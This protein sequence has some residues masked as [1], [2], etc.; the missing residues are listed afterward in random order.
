MNTH[1]KNVKMTPRGKDPVTLDHLSIRG[2]TIR[3]VILPDRRA[4]CSLPL[5]TSA[6]SGSKAWELPFL[7]LRSFDRCPFKRSLNLDALLVDDTPKTKQK[8]SSQQ[9]TAT[10]GRGRGAA[11]GRQQQSRGGRGA[12]GGRR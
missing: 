5:I 2:S 4:C 11:R 1:M 6:S 10:F 3:Y 9:Q 8:K 12:G 7:I